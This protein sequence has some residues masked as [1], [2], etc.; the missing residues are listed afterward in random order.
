M[1]LGDT[2]LEDVNDENE[3]T[4]WKPGV[5]DLGQFYGC[6]RVTKLMERMLH[7]INRDNDDG[8]HYY[9]HLIIRLEGAVLNGPRRWDKGYNRAPLW[10]RKAWQKPEDS[11]IE[12]CK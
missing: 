12:A 9:N 7:D 11:T 6:T 2:F 4:S 10:G 1:I 8:R 3:G 5:T